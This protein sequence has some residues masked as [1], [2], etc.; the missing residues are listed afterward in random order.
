[1]GLLRSGG[2]TLIAILLFLVL[3]VSNSLMA[4][5]MS[6]DYDTLQ[7]ELTGVA[8]EIIVEQGLDQQLVDGFPQMVE[9]CSNENVTELVYNESDLIS[10][11]PCDVVLDSQ[12]SIVSYVV[13][14]IV[15]EGYYKD[16]S[17]SFWEC[18]VTE[19]QIPTYLFS[20]MARDY[21]SGKFKLALTFVIILSILGFVIAEARKN[22][23]FLLGGLFILSALPFIKVSW[24][25]SL[26]GNFEVARIL[27][28]FFSQS[29]SVFLIMTIIGV[30]LILLGVVLK[31]LGLGSFIDNL[32]GGPKK[33]MKAEVKEEVKKEISSDSK[34]S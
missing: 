11:I 3:L 25:F 4:V 13:A 28:V 33:R 21:W 22:Y 14:N 12:E 16:Y 6:L 20:Q 29:F 31:F 26:F 24:F 1:M 27:G 19:G 5:T 8:N 10:D 7:P 9:E 32:M 23:P 15:E 18:S 34:K 2:L 17:C 30:V